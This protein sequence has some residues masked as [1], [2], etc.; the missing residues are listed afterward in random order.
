[1]KCTKCKA[2]IPEGKIYC[3]HCGSAIQM[4]P[5]YNP[6]DDITIGTKTRKK[7]LKP[8][9]EEYQTD[10]KMIGFRIR[11]W[12]YVLAGFFLLISGILIFR[13]SYNTTVEP[14]E[15]VAELPDAPVL[16][17][18]PTFNI[19]PGVYDYSPRITL[20]HEDRTNGQIYYTTDGTTPTAESS[21]YNHPIQAEEGITVI[22]AVF[23]RKD[24]MQSE[25]ANG[26]YEVVF[27]YPDEPV[28]SLPGGDYMG[29]FQVTLSAEPDC[30]IYYTTNGEEPGIHSTVYSGPIHIPVGLTVLQAISVDRDG[31]MSGI[32]EAI[33]N[34]SENIESDMTV[35]Q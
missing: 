13:I 33:Y 26:T 32:V 9:A 25:E 12:H 31:G 30:R 7:S 4:V 23:I 19:A 34:V 14:E 2:E 28:F 16:L 22:R 24:G 35:N 8:P 18:E 20:S 27:D 3:E 6:V 15:V 29:G 11:R 5:D 21:I 1:M 10:D 17:K